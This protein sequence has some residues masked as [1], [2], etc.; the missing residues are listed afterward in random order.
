MKTPRA[1]FEVMARNV[2]RK[3]KALFPD[4][5]VKPYI[6]KFNAIDAIYSALNQK[7]KSADVTEIIKR[8]SVYC[9]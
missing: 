6:K 8:T 2:F 3:Y 1:S 4:D 5:V 9:K 7:V